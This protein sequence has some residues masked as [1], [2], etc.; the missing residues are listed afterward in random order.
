MIVFRHWCWSFLGVVIESLPFIVMGAIISTI[1]QFYISEDVIRRI[2]PKRKVL[3]FLAAAF[4]GMVFPMCECAIVPVARSLIKKGVPVGIAIT[5]MLSV[6]IVNPFVIASTYYAFN[7]NF[8]IVLIRVIGGILCSI[9]VGMLISYIFKDTPIESIIADG[10]LDLSCACCSSDKK[11][12][13]SKI[14]KLH[15]II[16]QA[17][18][19]FLNISVYVILGA[20]I[21]SIFGSVINEEILNDY[22]FNNV[23]AVLIMLGISFLLSLCSE[24]DAFVAS[25]FLKNF[26][27]PS[28]S[29]FMI[30]GPMMDLK[31]AILTL[32]LFKKKFAT[33]LIILILMVVTAFSICLSF[34]SL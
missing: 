33:T 28:V 6:P 15:T 7:Y 3:A 18:N 21:S 9:I 14:D 20:F 34:I 1:I 19:E 26:G 27:V 32:G 10:Y 2:V 13:I 17:S 30:L 8:T 23:L 4:M 11:Y 12:Y 25:K 5:F 24:A 22:T 29:A 31:N 16:C